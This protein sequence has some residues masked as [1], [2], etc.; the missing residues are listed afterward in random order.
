M[1]SRCDFIEGLKPPSEVVA[2]LWV[3]KRELR[4]IDSVSVGSKACAPHRYTALT[5]KPKGTHRRGGDSGSTQQAHLARN[6]QQLVPVDK[7]GVNADC[8]R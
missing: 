1:L 2:V 4:G 5:R 8:F 3:Q 7:R 6:R